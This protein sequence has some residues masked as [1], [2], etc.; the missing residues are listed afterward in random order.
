MALTI[1]GPS[2]G[3]E[4][5]ARSAGLYLYG[6]VRAN[7]PL[8]VGEE[9]VGGAPVTMIEGDGVAAMVSPAEDSGIRLKRQDLHRHLRVI[10]SAFKATTILPCPFGTIVD[11]ESELREGVLVGA[12]DD[13]LAGLTRLDGTV[14]INVKATYDEEELLRRIVAADPQIAA[15]RERTR[16]AGDAGY[17]DRLQLGEIVAG[18]IG[19]QAELD[20]GRLAGLLAVNAVDI[21]VE[22]PEAGCALKASFLVTRKLLGRFDATLEALARDEQ[23]LLQFEAIG[24][25]PPTA[26]AAAY[27]ST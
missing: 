20:G 12:R 5:A 13:L 14:Q 6:F 2:D 10:E 27:A 7:A 17:Y 1:A 8:S 3:E 21:A 11:S 23:P 22:P 15:L 16:A 19:E 18:R 26:F 4:D 25:L 9:G 24:P